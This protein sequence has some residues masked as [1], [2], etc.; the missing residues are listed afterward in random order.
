MWY[1]LREGFGL[2]GVM[3]RECRLRDGKGI[4]A[5][6]REWSLKTL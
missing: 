2:A 3:Q 5:L 6:R 4:A 1:K